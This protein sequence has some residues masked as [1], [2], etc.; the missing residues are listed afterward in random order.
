MP[1]GLFQSGRYRI[2]II[3]VGWPVLG[4]VL[5]EAGPLAGQPSLHFLTGVSDPLIGVL[6]TAPKGNTK[7]TFGQH[8]KFDPRL[9]VV[10]VRGLGQRTAEALGPKTTKLFRYI[11]KNRDIANV[12]TFQGRQGGATRSGV[13][14]GI[15]AAGVRYMLRSTRGCRSSTSQGSTGRAKAAVIS[16]A[17]S[18]RTP[19]TINEAMKMHKLCGYGSLACANCVKV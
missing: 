17:E 4:D 6:F 5:P 15:V 18:T 3:F 12:H 1:E 13:I 10:V 9:E 14:G 19:T 2:I 16:A 8:L 11:F 7:H